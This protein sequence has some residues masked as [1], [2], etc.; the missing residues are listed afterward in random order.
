[1]VVVAPGHVTHKGDVVTVKRD[2]VDLDFPLVAAVGL[3]KTG[4]EEF[5]LYSPDLN[6]KLE[7]I[8][9]KHAG[10]AMKFY[11]ELFG[12][13]HGN[14]DPVRMV[15]APR[16]GAGYER[17]GFISVSDAKDELA[18]TNEIPEEGPTRLLAHEIAHAWWWRGDPMTEDRW[19]FESMAEYSA[20][21][22]IE[23]ELGMEKR[24]I[25][26]ERKY[27]PAET[28]GPVLGRGRGNTASVYQKGPLLLIKLEEKLGRPTMDKFLRA[29]ADKPPRT[30]AEWLATLQASAGPA[31]RE[32][33]E[34]AL[35]A[36]TMTM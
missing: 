36:E 2:V 18:K 6:G 10:P 3:Q 25:L 4:N 15:V 13:L 1:M 27:K 35:R 32:E 26:V 23:A 11:N 22:F 34:K 16:T 24:N 20:I 30:T 28:A 17:R 9:R 14:K 33:F 31:V 21:R 29:L 8:Y 5:E 19:L 7:T 12:P